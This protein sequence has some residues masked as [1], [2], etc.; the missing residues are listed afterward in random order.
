MPDFYVD[1]LEISPS[2]FLDACSRD[3]INQV[4]SILIED[5]FI[6]PS[7]LLS[8]DYNP[9]ES[10]FIESLTKL[11]QSK[12]RLTIEEEGLIMNIVNRL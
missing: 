6:S 2:D 5:G 11:A 1:D 4:I 3:E 7:Q 10:I 12:Y 9:E 8:G